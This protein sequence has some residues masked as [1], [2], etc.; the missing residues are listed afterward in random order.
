MCVSSR[1][2]IILSYFQRLSKV[3]KQFSP[4]C[5]DNV[6]L[7]KSFLKKSPSRCIS[8]CHQHLKLD[9]FSQQYP[10]L[11]SFFLQNCSLGAPNISKHNNIQ[12]ILSGVKILREVKKKTR[13]SS[14]KTNIGHVIW[15]S[16]CEL[17]PIFNESEGSGDPIIINE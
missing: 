4:L 2:S 3:L 10:L 1:T 17:D 13:K 14:K 12:N 9:Q 7:T 16:Q 15:S 8:S 6:H 11:S 5:G